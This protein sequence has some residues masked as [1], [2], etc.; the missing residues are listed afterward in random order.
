MVSKSFSDG[1]EAF[2]DFPYGAF[3]FGSDGGNSC[4]ARGTREGGESDGLADLFKGSG[5]ANA[6]VGR[7]RTQGI[8]MLGSV[9]E[10]QR[11]DLGGPFFPHGPFKLADTYT[12]LDV[13]RLACGTGPGHPS[14]EQIA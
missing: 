13:E 3:S 14:I 6:D 4:G 8:E 5:G 7:G 11:E 10:K 1:V 9:C 2:G 12:H